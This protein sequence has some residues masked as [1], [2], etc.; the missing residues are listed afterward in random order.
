MNRLYTF[1]AF[2]PLLISCNGTNNTSS[3]GEFNDTGVLSENGKVENIDSVPTE[4]IQQSTHEDFMVFFDNFMWSI[5]LQKERVRFPIQMDTI[6][7]ASF[8]DW[9]YL[10][11][12]T[13]KN[14][15]PLL[16][17]NLDSEFSEGMKE[18]SIVLSILNFKYSKSNNYEFKNDNNKW[19]LTKTYSTLLNENSDYEFLTFLLEFSKD[20]IFQKQHIRFPV[21]S[22]YADSDN[23][24]DT[25]VDTLNKSKWKFIDLED[26]IGTLLVHDNPMIES[27]HRTFMIRGI[28]TGIYVNFY[29]QLVNEEWELIKLEDLST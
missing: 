1:L 21:L 27:K 5:D 14:R 11:F 18:D 13:S 7:L 25:A 26:E 28:E 16:S 9:K 10:P 24:Y 12:Y 22:Y 15:M 6:T 3:K 20:S 4:I 17:Y 29:F 19:T 23:D 8:A 2:I